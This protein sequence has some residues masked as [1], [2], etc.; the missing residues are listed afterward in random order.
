MGSSDNPIVLILPEDAEASL[1]APVL[2]TFS[3]AAL[4]DA[5]PLH[6]VT[7]GKPPEALAG[8]PGLTWHT[9]DASGGSGHRRMLAVGRFLRQAYLRQ[10][11][12][13]VITL[14]TVDQH[15]AGWWRALFSP[16]TFNL[17]LWLAAEPL[18]KSF[19][20]R[21]TLNR[22]TACNVFV[23]AELAQAMGSNSNH[24]LLLD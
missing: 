2:R 16:Q 17:R 8:T 3:H 10:P 13:F 20:Q 22:Q 24:D 9:L 6:V 1:I 21:L 18:Q 4:S 15:A 14:A 11:F 7:C 23:S 19:W 5:F 12:K